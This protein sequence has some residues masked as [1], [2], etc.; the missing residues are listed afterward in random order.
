MKIKT[1]IQASIENNKP[2]VVYNFEK[3]T[4]LFRAISA[5]I[6]DIAYESGKSYEQIINYVYKGKEINEKENNQ[7]EQIDNQNLQQISKYFKRESSN[8]EL[9]SNITKQQDLYNQQQISYPTE[10]AQNGQEYRQGINNHQQYRRNEFRFEEKEEPIHI[11]PEPLEI[12]FNRSGIDSTYIR[13]VEYAM[14]NTKWY[15]ARFGAPAGMY[16]VIVENREAMKP[17]ERIEIFEAAMLN[18]EWIISNRTDLNKYNI[19]AF[20]KH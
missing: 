20:A 16:Y 13:K 5:I 6:E 19:I 11:F 9:N 3:N 4:E 12:I 8:D 7:N 15:D 18:E 17:S 14:P 2:H 10:F 1:M